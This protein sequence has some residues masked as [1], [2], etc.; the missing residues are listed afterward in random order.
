[1]KQV[2]LLSI[3]ATSLL[4]GNNYT[5]K[6]ASRHIGKHATVCGMVSEE[7]Y[8]KRSNGQPTFINLDGR[9]PNQK[10][11]IFILG[12]NRH[13]F[14]SAERSYNGKTICVTGLITWH[15]GIPLIKVSDKSQIR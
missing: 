1:M 13:N 6:E 9:Y 4:F 5:T 8:A 12:K 2:L 15:K 3:I 10:F 7:Y 14:S 11:T